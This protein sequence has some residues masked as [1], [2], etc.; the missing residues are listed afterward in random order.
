MDILTFLARLIEALSWPLAIVVLVVVLRKEVRGLV[1]TLSRIKAGPVEAEFGREVAKL[2][3]STEG[4][5]ELPPPEQL[6]P[7]K[8]MLLE[9]AGINPRSAILEA[10]IGVEEALRQLAYSQG[11]VNPLPA[12]GPGPAIGSYGGYA[13]PPEPPDYGARAGS[14][15][16]GPSGSLVFRKE[17][18]L[19]QEELSLYR[20]LRALR[21]QV[22]HAGD[23]VPTPETA[24]YYIELTSRLK[25]ALTR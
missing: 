1:A 4:V 9:L 15:G 18:F 5:D 22:A 24:L 21:N 16:Y 25:R 17:D 7:E 20:H 2:Q 8:R 14:G 3:A 11:A 12:Y 19:T 23:L 10:W 6:T 13:S